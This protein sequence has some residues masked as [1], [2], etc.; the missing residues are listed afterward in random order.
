[1]QNFKFNQD[2]EV[3]NLFKERLYLLL[4]KYKLLLTQSSFT[5][6]NLYV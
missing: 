3:I 2:L 5:E 4:K 1:M 6:A